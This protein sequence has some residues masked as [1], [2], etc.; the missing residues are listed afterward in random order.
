MAAGSA[1]SASRTGMVRKDTKQSPQAW[2]P[3]VQVS[4]SIFMPPT[5]GAGSDTDGGRIR[6]GAV[7]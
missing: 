6:V 4:Q 3:A 7:T 5:L 1:G 2:G